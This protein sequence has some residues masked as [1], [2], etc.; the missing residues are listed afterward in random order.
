[1][2]LL[3]AYLFYLFFCLLFL[4]SAFY[5]TL[6]FA[7]P[8]AHQKLSETTL[9]LNVGSA[10]LVTA[11]SGKAYIL[12]N[13]HVCLEENWKGQILGRFDNGRAVSGRISKE[14]PLLDLCA[15][16]IEGNYP[17][18]TI[19]KQASFNEKIVTRGYP[20]GIVTESEGI[21]GTETT[22]EHSIEIERVGEC[23]EGFTAER[24]LANNRI[25]ACTVHWT[26]YLTSL[27]SRPGSS[28]SPVVNAAGDLLGVVSSW[29]PARR[30][31]AGVVPLSS[32]QKFFRGL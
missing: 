27:Y 14:S 16:L 31:E 32:V 26:S 12:T 29:H 4:A 8:M 3:G 30:F 18:L 7:S 2:K 15:A 17:S 22:W 25:E 6:A 19:A 21:I 1:M 28:G 20:L 9:R 24:S 10:S 23:P 5:V 11:P 13:W